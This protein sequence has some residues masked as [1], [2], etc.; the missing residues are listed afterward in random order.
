MIN[1]DINRLS[2]NLH[3]VS[4]ML[5]EQAVEGLEQE[6][7]RRLGFLADGDLAN[8]DIAELSLGPVHS[9]THLDAAGLRS[10]LVERLVEIMQRHARGEPE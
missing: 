2:I 6:L 7:R 5:A 3:G 8:F 10:L 9:T 4:P 1:I